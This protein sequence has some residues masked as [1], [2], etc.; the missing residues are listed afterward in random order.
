M[1]MKAFLLLLVSSGTLI[2]AVAADNADKKNNEAEKKWRR[3]MEGPHV[4]RG[5][6]CD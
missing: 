4:T 1:P 3:L 5:V 6:L 2:S